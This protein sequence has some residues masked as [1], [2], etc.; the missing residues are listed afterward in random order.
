MNR[1]VIK[2]IKYSNYTLMATTN[3]NQIYTN[4]KHII[5]FKYRPFLVKCGKCDTTSFLY[6]KY[7]RLISVKSFMNH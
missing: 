6:L 7:L 2:Q 4:S 1:I 5:S 3:I